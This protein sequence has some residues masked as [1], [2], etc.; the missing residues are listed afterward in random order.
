MSPD[1]TVNATTDCPA[2]GPPGV[3]KTAGTGGSST[4]RDGFGW[5]C[6]DISTDPAKPVNSC[7]D[8]GACCSPYFLWN[9]SKKNMSNTASN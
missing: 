8:P 2:Y 3:I 4:K 9:F 5:A 6:K 1:S 7:Y